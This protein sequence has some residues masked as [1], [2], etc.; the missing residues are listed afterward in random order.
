MS[1][2]H[3]QSCEAVHTGLDL[4]NIP[5]TQ[6]AV[7][8]GS[9]VEYQP[10]ATV[11]P[12][13]PIDFFISGATSD[14]L[15]LSNTY[16]HVRAK[17]TLPDGT[18]IPGDANVAPTN[19]WLHTLF[20]QVDILLNGTLIT[21][22]DNNY[23][24][25]AYIEATLNHGRDAKRSH[26]TTAFYYRDT[27]G[28]LDST[29]GNAN[30]GLEVRRDLTAGSRE[31]DM[32]GRLH[33]DIMHQE[34]YMLNGV[35]VKITLNPSKNEFNLMAHDPDTGFKAVLT[36]VSLFVRK[37]RLSSHVSLAHEK[38]LAQ[39]NAKYP[40]NRVVQKTFAIATGS[41]S[42][43]R[44][45]LFMHQTPK[46]LVVGLVSS[47]AFSGRYNRNPFNF[48]TF[49]LSYLS[50]TLN[51]KQVPAKALTP[52]FDHRLFARSY[53][54]LMLATGLVNRDN[55]SYIEYR[56]FDRGYALY[57]F[58]LTPSLLDGD[59]L[60]ELVRS[61]SLSLDLKFSQALVEP[62]T[63]VV[64]GEMDGMIEIDRSRQVLVDFAA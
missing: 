48:M 51:G 4:F 10:L 60:F 34:R 24:Y 40:V 36:H 2:V 9:F 13:S 45:N 59:N 3:P 49:N 29:Q 8:D 39:G 37:A 5:P 52:D 32:I 15:D 58:D 63:V 27:Q 62:V 7:E 14:Y 21:S 17:I 56:D 19:Y 64:Y 30:H 12:G 42:C 55:G 35:D 11:S 1:L 38:A 57:G 41:F 18:N 20:S 54:S 6:T 46:K 47:Q 28:V 23:P 16:L 61:A 50:V 22:S 26:L 33:A 44:D 43:V 25:R 53:H 31:V